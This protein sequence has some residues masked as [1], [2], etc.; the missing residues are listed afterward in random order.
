MDNLPWELVMLIGGLVGFVIGLLG[1]SKIG[2]SVGSK[3]RPKK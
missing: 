1:G 3:P 2:F